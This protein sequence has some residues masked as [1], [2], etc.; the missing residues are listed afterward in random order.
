MASES[1]QPG[2]IPETHSAVAAVAPPR[3]AAAQGERR[4][5]RTF[6]SLADPSFRWFF[7]SMASWFAA[8]NMQQL[9]N[10][11]IVFNLTG[12]YAALGLVSLVTS[13]PMLFLSL[14]GGVIA[15]RFSKPRVIQAGQIVNTIV[16]GSLAI[17]MLSG[18]LVFEYLLVAGFVQ[19]VVFGLI[20][21][22]RQTMIGDVVSEEKLMNGVALNATGQNVM[23]LAAPPIGGILLTVVGAGWVYVTMSVLYGIASF[24]MLPVRPRPDAARVAR[25]RVAG[26]RNLGFHDMV[27]GCRYIWRDKTVLLILMTN[28]VVVLLAMPIQQMLPGFVSDVLKGNGI[29]LGV[30]MSLIGLGSV[31][32]SLWV[33]SISSRNRGALLM[34]SAVI[35]GASLLGFA[36]SSFFWFSALMAI[37]LGV[38]QAGR[39]SISSVLIQSYAAPEYRGRVMSVYM[40]QFG[41]VAF[42]T[43]LVGI[44]ASA[45]GIQIALALT[46]AVLLAFALFTLAAMPAIRRLA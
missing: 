20:M 40:M 41:L 11:F 7:L 28:C 13:V 16:A 27:E 18:I 42:G 1:V 3:P 45:I 14:P 2:V 32:G 12:S 9:V 36:L 34:V 17:T 19:G 37:V 38:G 23:R 43:F 31:A 21:P 25:P 33:A 10:G 4:K 26:E 15:D 24:C 22:S 6:E 8:M 44:L 29:G 5:L 39:I 46:G 35:L 30:I